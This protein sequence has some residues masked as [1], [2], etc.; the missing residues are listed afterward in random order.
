ML[1]QLSSVFFWLWVSMSCCMSRTMFIYLLCVHKYTLFLL[2]SQSHT[3]KRTQN[4]VG[5]NVVVVKSFKVKQS[6][7]SSYHKNSKEE[8][9]R[10]SVYWRG[11]YT[12]VSNVLINS[13][14]YGVCECV[15]VSACGDILIAH[16]NVTNLN[17]Y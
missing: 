3:W 5:I 1:Y 8:Q 9:K 10:I 2:K 16:S 12:I 15:F 14:M 13:Y 6:P 7:P 17:L 4:I 11:T